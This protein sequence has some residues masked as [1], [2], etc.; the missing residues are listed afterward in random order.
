M[1]NTYLFNTVHGSDEMSEPTVINGSPL[2]VRTFGIFIGGLVHN[3]HE[4]GAI[5]N[6]GGVRS[7][8]RFANT[9]NIPV[10]FKGNCD[11][12]GRYLYKISCFGYR[13]HFM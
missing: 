11:C 4:N 10:H 5:R 7:R 3:V 13:E 12:R 8:N 1:L 9:G 6:L 2:I